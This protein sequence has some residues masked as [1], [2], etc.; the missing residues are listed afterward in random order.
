MLDA[1]CHGSLRS[2]R[3]ILDVIS[4]LQL[5]GIIGTLLVVFF[6]VIKPEASNGLTLFSR[7]T[8]WALHVGLGLLALLL[9]STWFKY[10]TWLPDTKLAS[11][12]ITGCA[13]AIVST[14]GYIALDSVFA[15]S[16]IDLDPD[17]PAD[18]P[19]I[20][21]IAEFFELLPLFLITWLLIN[22]PLFTGNSK[23]D[24][25][26][27]DSGSKK[28]LDAPEHKPDC[29]QLVRR[30]ERQSGQPFTEKT[31]FLNSLPGFI[32]TEIIA[33]SSDLHYLNVWTEQGRA[34]VLGNLR[35]AV[36][37]LGD[38][39]M[40]IHRSHWVASKHV[41]RVVGNSNKGACLLSNDLRIPISRRRWK[42]VQQYYGRGVLG[43]S[44]HSGT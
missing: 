33:V 14:P 11:I 39:G 35:D 10:G 5:I 2:N 40:Q 12:T 13:A 38:T 24:N 6:T 18:N 44:A 30:P 1:R 41:T 22:L 15:S 28:A 3:T 43:G 37:E 26:A 16:I 34:T 7:L 4:V 32:G 21:V 8:F 31:G 23:T 9:A 29:D 27:A 36:S 25:A 19:A 20:A 42:K 17:T